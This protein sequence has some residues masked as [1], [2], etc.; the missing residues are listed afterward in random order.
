MTNSYLLEIIKALQPE[1]REEIAALLSVPQ[2]NR[3]GNAK[4]I[5]RLYHV[6]LGAAPEFPAHMLHKN[7]VYVRVFSE[8]T[9]VPGK[10][11]KLM[12]ELNK[13]LRNYALTR[14]FLAETNE[15][16]QQIDWV[17]WLRSRGLVERAH[18]VITKLKVQKEKPEPESLERYR[19][20]LLISEEKYQMETL[21]NQFKGDLSI[22]DLIN[23]L[24]LYYHNYK[25][26]LVNH[27]KNQQ[28]SA[29][30]ADLLWANMGADFWE[31]KSVLLQISSGINKIISKS[32]PSV[33]EFQVFMELLQYH[34]ATLSF[35][36]L[37][38][39]YSYLRNT[40][41]LL[42][43]GG[44]MEFI[45]VLHEIHKDN[46]QRGYFLLNGEISPNVYLNLVQIAT[47]AN[48]REWA[49]KFT[50]AY[51]TVILGGDENQFFYRLN[52]AQCLFAEGNFDEASKYIP[53]L[54][55]AS[56]YHNMARRLELKVY[57]ELDSELL[58]YKIDAFRKFVER[59][60]S[61]T[62]APDQKSMLINF[63][64]LLLQLMQSP[65]KDK[66]RSALLIERIN[67]K[68]LVA[69]R[70]WLLEKARELG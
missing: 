67:S 17:R 15:V 62:M 61:K 69:E 54:P 4:E 68:K 11:E 35:Q 14:Q 1:E 46:L 63:V 22:P 2:L 43:N 51:K 13:F 25:M 12:A 37:A 50:E 24:E 5:E 10:L 59:T 42:I 26:D 58:P 41:T 16:H 27:F 65:K 60:A 49:R 55:S 6:I 53:E 7:E 21:R 19:D 40:C 18:H 38:E 47:R 29:Q 36:T 64:N 9:P 44:N 33:K 45:P 56:H 8:P 23:D 31:A 3:S 39:C 28:K 30:L 48:E 32:L 57:Y 70:A 34:E 20:A 52:L 66:E